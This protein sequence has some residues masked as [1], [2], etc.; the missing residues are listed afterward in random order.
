[1]VF[2]GSGK[3]LEDG[4]KADTTDNHF[5]GVWDRGTT[6][7]N[8]TVS[9]LVEQTFEAGYNVWIDTNGNAIQDP[10]EQFP[11]RVLSDNPVV[12]NGLN[13]FGWFMELPDNG[14][15]SITTPVVRGKIVFF[16]T[17][18]PDDDPC[19]TGGGG[20]RMAVNLITGGEPSDDIIDVNGDGVIDANDRA[21]DGN[22]NPRVVSGV[23][24]DG[25]LPEPVFIEDISY[26]ADTPSKVA[27][28]EEL[29]TGRYSWQELLQ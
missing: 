1:M 7:Q 15:R 12:Y 5:Y 24:Q 25:F 20:Y 27:A 19:E 3:F 21:D 2:F 8:R 10:G 22:N 9:H 16:N 29:P 11:Q 23:S 14:E 26:T 6:Y 4:D 13:D 18:T 17:Y 28:L